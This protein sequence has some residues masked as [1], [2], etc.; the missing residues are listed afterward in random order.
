M[1]KTNLIGQRFGKWTVLEEA[2]KKD[3]RTTWLCQCDCGTKRAV[4]E[5]SL[6]SGRSQSCGCSRGGTNK[7]DLRGQTFGDLTVLS[8]A[9]NKDNG[10]TAWYCQCKCGNTIVV[11]TKELR[12]GDTKSC[13]CLWD[14]TVK[15]NL[16]GQRFGKLTVLQEVK[17]SS[18]SYDGVIWQCKC[19]C[20]NIVNVSGHRLR[21]GH[22]LSCGCLSSKGEAKIKQLLEANNI[23]YISQFV[24]QDCLTEHGY[25]CRFDFAIIND[26]NIQCIIEYDGS[27]HFTQI[28]GS[29]W[30]SV[31]DI[32]ARDALKTTYCQTHNIPLIRISYKDY[33]ELTIEYLKERMLKCQNMLD[34]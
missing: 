12:N 21:S 9:P 19:D 8:P 25:P 6:T 34:T 29:S 15:A 17:D 20:G 11:G 31:A 14:R 2:P 16:V 33:N 4:I 7:L 18:L 26:N 1:S 3:G 32:Q 5:K 30:P 28:K 23:N 22:T 10:R 13:G 27:Q 24:F